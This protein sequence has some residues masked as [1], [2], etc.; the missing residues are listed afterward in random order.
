VMIGGS[1]R[2]IRLDTLEA[3]GAER[4]NA[5]VG[6]VRNAR[7]EAKNQE[8]SRQVKLM[9]LAREVDRMQMERLQ[10]SL[11]VPNWHV[12]T[13][14]S[15]NVEQRRTRANDP[16]HFVPPELRRRALREIESSAAW[17]EKPQRVPRTAPAAFGRLDGSIDGSTHGESELLSSL[18]DTLT[19]RES[20]MLPR[21]SK[22]S[23]N[24]RTSI[25]SCVGARESKA[26]GT[27]GSKSARASASTRGS[28]LGNMAP[29]SSK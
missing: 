7:L 29:L 15:V 4:L 2:C 13:W 22:E 12:A 25:G 11:Q 6:E 18:G 16:L 24:A 20:T 5:L 17:H 1:P 10:Y 23:K 3:E 8:M 9:A 28:V 19:P 14:R 26:A 27:R 21:G